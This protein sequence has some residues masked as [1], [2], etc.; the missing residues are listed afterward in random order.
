MTKEEVVDALNRMD[1]GS[2][3]HIEGPFIAKGDVVF[4][5]NLFEDLE[6]ENLNPIEEIQNIVEVIKAE[7]GY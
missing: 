7:Q 2:A 1:G 3:W 5:W 4:N 6:V